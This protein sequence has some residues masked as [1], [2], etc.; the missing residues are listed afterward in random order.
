M[1]IK[2]KRYRHGHASKGVTP[3]Y[4]TYCRMRS[5]CE[6]SDNKSFKNYGGRGIIVEWKSFKDFLR[7]MGKRPS[8]NHSIERIDNDG[9]YS[10]KNCRW[11]TRKEQARN[12]RNNIFV[13]F[14]GKTMSLPEASERSGL[15]LG[16]LYFRIKKLGLRGEELFQPLM[17]NYR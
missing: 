17:R 9:P 13:S 7:D 5:R 10:K 14:N 6:W 8:L 16:T 3:E 4:N 12:R 1:K 2:D 15:K 11:A